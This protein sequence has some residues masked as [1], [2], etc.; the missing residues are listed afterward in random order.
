VAHRRRAHARRDD[1]PLRRDADFPDESR[2]WSMVE[3]HRATHL[4]ISP[5]AI[6]GL[7]RAGE[8][9]V[10]RHD[11][12]ASSSSAA[13]ASRGIPSR[14]GGT[15][16]RSAMRAV[17]SSTTP[18]ARRSPAGSSAARPGRT[19]SPAPSAARSPGW[20]PTSSTNG[21]SVRGAVGELVLRAPWPGMTRGF[22]KDRD[23]Y[24]ETYWPAPERV[25]PW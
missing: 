12:R 13:P 14:G 3:R 6:R 15:S 16:A 4:G 17:R 5:T 7:M 19:S 2:I 18:A 22:W 1:R 9:P 20:P 23:R 25:G 8:D 24:I 11:R 21:R 10:R